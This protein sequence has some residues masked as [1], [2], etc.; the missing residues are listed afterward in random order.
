[1]T[2]FTKNNNWSNNIKALPVYPLIIFD[3]LN[4]FE[5]PSYNIIFRY[6]GYKISL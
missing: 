1:M 3:Q 2:E 4:K 6:L 5:S